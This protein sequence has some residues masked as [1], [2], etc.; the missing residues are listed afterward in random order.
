MYRNKIIHLKIGPIELELERKHIIVLFNVLL[1]GRD[2]A[3]LGMPF[4]QKYN[5]R[6]DWI[7][8]DVEF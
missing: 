8:K 2:E 3:V 7:I 1:L 6:I 4:L 5:P